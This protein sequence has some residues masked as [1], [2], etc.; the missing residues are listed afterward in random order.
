M[1][2]ETFN[3]KIM[4]PPGYGPTVTVTARGVL[5]LSQGA[6]NALG[7][8]SSVELLFDRDRR[9]IGIRASNKP[10][11]YPVSASRVIHCTAFT[12]E[13]GITGTQAVRR[14][15]TLQTS[16]VLGQGSMLVVDVN[17]PGTVVDSNRR[18]DQV[19]T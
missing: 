18:K 11:A 15:A 8:P 3:P 14:P 10:H 5:S 2:F 1:A 12:Q 4:Q 7:Q 6:V 9:L 13:F 19:T 16:Q 17:D